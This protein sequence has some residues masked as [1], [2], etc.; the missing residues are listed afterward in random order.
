MKL[1]EQLFSNNWTFYVVISFIWIGMF[2]IGHIIEREFEDTKTKTVEF[3]KE[4]KKESSQ[5]N[6]IKKELD[7][8][9][10][11]I[12]ANRD[13]FSEFEH[14]LN[15]K[16]RDLRKLENKFDRKID[17]KTRSRWHYFNME[18]FCQR[19]ERLNSGW[20]CPDLEEITKHNKM[21]KK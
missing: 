16:T 19:A 6:T 4:L 9:S 21:E 14:R 15:R 10:E 8:R 11:I 13:I 12:R 18:E 5:I 1:I 2:Y 3:K 20:K 7:R 17:E